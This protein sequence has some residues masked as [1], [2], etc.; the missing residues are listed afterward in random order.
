M[1]QMTFL[2][3]VNEAILE[4]KVTLDPLD[5]TSWANP[6]RTVMYN[7]FKKWVNTAYTELF[8][9]DNDWYFRKGRLNYTIYPRLQLTNVATSL[10]IGDHLVGSQSGVG[11]TVMD[12]HNFEQGSDPLVV[13][14]TVSI[15][16]DSP[17]TV[18]PIFQEQ[19]NRTGPVP[20]TGIANIKGIGYYDLRNEQPGVEMI[21]KETVR[22]FPIPGSN[23]SYPYYTYPNKLAG[24]PLTVVRYDD[25]NPN[26]SQAVWADGIPNQIMEMPNGFYQ[27]IPQPLNPFMVQF[28]YTKKV[29]PL[30]NPDDIPYALPEEYHPYLYWKAI[31]EYSDFD[32]NPAVFARAN[33]H[34]S[35]YDFYLFRDQQKIPAF[36]TRGYW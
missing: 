28:D 36:K 26:Y 10:N 35:K 16:F 15:V 3:L 1:A 19:I 17:H 22:A 30:V 9:H 32:R 20:Y 31:E 8:E 34:T 23:Y 27:L 24:L 14:V 29:T 6:P 33:K 4:S 21:D 7:R 5:A 11:F 18:S 2:E 25:F 12:I 13:D